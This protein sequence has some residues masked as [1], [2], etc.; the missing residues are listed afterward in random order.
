MGLGLWHVLCK[1]FEVLETEVHVMDA[2][3]HFL[4]KLLRTFFK[5]YS[6]GSEESF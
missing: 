6:A 5:L 3:S 4:L 1:Y 2:S